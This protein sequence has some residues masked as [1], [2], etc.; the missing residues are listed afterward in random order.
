MNRKFLDPPKKILKNLHLTELNTFI[1]Y[2]L[3]KYDI[4]DTERTSENLKAH[5][6]HLW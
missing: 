2:S 6:K 4:E 1:H 5:I 3:V